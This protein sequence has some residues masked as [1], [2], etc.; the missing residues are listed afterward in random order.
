MISTDKICSRRV[1]VPTNFSGTDLR[2]L[3]EAAN[4]LWSYGSIIIGTAVVVVLG[5]W[6]FVQNGTSHDNLISSFG[7]V[8]Q[9]PEVC[10]ARSTFR[11]L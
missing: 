7:A 10:R 11:A 8:L 6:A 1:N 3:Y 5:M 9:N 2:Y 4:L